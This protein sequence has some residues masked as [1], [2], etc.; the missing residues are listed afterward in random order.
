MKSVFQELSPLS[1]SLQKGEWVLSRL[2]HKP[3]PQPL[4]SMNTIKE[5]LGSCS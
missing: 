5:L 2:S 4:E 3:N 1:S